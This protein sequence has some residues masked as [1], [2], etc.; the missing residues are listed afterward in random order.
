MLYVCFLCSS[1]MLDWFYLLLVV[2]FSYLLGSFPSAVVISKSFF[3]FDIREKGSGNMGST[4]AFRIL[5]WKW[6]ILVQVLDLLKGILA[7]IVVANL[8][9]QDIHVLSNS[10]FEDLTVV[11]IIAGISAVIGHVWTCFAGFKGGK[12]INTATGMLIAIAPIDVSIAVGIFILA[13]IFSG[14]I[15]LGS[16]AAAFSLPSSMFVRYNLFHV[17]IPGYQ[18]L[19]YFA[20]VL[21]LLIFYTHRSNIKRLLRGEENR[22]AKLQLVKVF[23]S[24]NK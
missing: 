16:L 6:G 4:N 13:V 15:S 1:V 17:D 18:I 10:Y 7:V 8:L 19:I 11:K 24:K 9:G 20:L 14:Y 21:T 5:G 3:G 23:N 22:F 12:G 2:I